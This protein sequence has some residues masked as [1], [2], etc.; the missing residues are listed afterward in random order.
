[1]F[2]WIIDGFLDGDWQPL[3]LMVVLVLSALVAGVMM[4]K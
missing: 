1:M 4:Y 2:W 3:I